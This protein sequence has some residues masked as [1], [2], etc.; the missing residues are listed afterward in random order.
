LEIYGFFFNSILEN[1]DCKVNRCV[2]KVGKNQRP[3]PHVCALKC[4]LCPKTEYE[5]GAPGPRHLDGRRSGGLDTSHW[6]KLLQELTVPFARSGSRP[7][8]SSFADLG[9]TKKDELLEC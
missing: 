1:P 5:W 6:R 9:S 3:P 4:W 7:R 2:I 8:G